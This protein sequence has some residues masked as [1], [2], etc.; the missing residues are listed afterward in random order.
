MFTTSANPDHN[1]RFAR[2]RLPC[3]AGYGGL[4]GIHTAMGFDLRHIPRI[5]SRIVRMEGHVY[6]LWSP[7]STQLPFL[8][9][10]PRPD[11][12]PGTPRLLSERRY[13]GHAGRHDCLHAPQ[14]YRSRA[15]HW[16]FMRRASMVLPGDY[17][18]LAYAPLTRFWQRDPANPF[19][20]AFD[21]PF[22]AGLSALRR[23]L[24]QQMET[25]RDLASYRSR[26]RPSNKPTDWE[27]R[28]AYATEDS[29]ARL[30]A[31]RT[32]DEAVD[33]G[34][35]VQ[36]GLREKEA[37]LHLFEARNQQ[38]RLPF[39]LLK[40]EDMPLAQERFIGV[41]INGADEELTLRYMRAGVPCFIAHEYTSSTLTRDQVSVVKVY[42]D[43]LEGTELPELL[44]D[45]NPYQR[46]ARNQGAL[47]NIVLG[48]DGRGL[49]LPALATDE[50]RSS[51]LFLEQLAPLETS[52]LPSRAPSP[53]R[54]DRQS[55]GAPSQAAP[56]KDWRP[57]PRPPSPREARS[58]IEKPWAQAGWSA[59]APS[60]PS[61]ADILPHA[62]EAP[63]SSR[64][65]RDKYQARPLEYQSV[66]PQRSSWIVPP[67]IQKAPDKGKWVKFELDEVHQLPAFV[68]RGA[69]AEVESSNL[70]YDRENKRRLYFGHFVPP[71]GVLDEDRFGAPVPRYPFFAEDGNR[72]APQPP[73]NWMYTTPDS[74]RYN[75]GKRA[76]A[77]AP[78]RLPLLTRDGNTAEQ[79][80]K[81]KGKVAEAGEEESEEEEHGMEVDVPNPSD[82][83]SSVV[84]L[85]G[86]DAQISAVEFARL[87][88][89]A[90]YA[91]RA[92]PLM[93]I[94]AQGRMWL[95]F[96][97]ITQGRGAFGAL[98]GVAR[99]IGVQFRPVAE[100]EE[101]VLY[102]TD[103]WYPE[104]DDE[105]P[106]QDVV[107]EM[108]SGIEEI[109]VSAGS[110]AVKAVSPSPPDSP[111][112]LMPT[113]PPVAPEP[114]SSR[115]NTR[116]GSKRSPESKAAQTPPTPTPVAPSSATAIPPSSTA[117][118]PLRTPAPSLRPSKPPPPPPSAPRAM[119]AATAPFNKP[120]LSDRLT[121]APVETTALPSGPTTPLIQR[122]EGGALPLARRLTDASQPL[123]QRLQPAPLLLR[124][125]H[126]SVSTAGDMAQ[127]EER[128]SASD[129]DA[130]PKAEGR[131]KGKRKV[132]RGTR[133]GKLAKEQARLKEERRAAREETSLL[134]SPVSTPA[135]S[136]SQ[137]SVVASSSAMTLDL[138][139]LP[140]NPANSTMSWDEYESGPFEAFVPPIQEQPLQPAPELG[141]PGATEPWQSS[142]Y[143]EEEVALRW[144]NEEDEEDRP[145]AGPF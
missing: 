26:S 4:P 18:E 57:Y 87:G 139:A 144:D 97:T 39:A 45:N 121:D 20:G 82:E 51:S 22:I 9:G 124:M 62:I 111:P 86:L 71:E 132:R 52:P 40:K 43:F 74:P 27:T 38:R 143:E 126:A 83:P 41:W 95:R 30:L 110:S 7:N 32:W 98:G 69:N 49:Q 99:D 119:R 73:S 66:D 90:F 141:P 8:A 17:A 70:W 44:G 79:A 10:V 21:P 2:T 34:V 53:S 3:L 13:D 85:D 120:P 37:W 16:P 48:D 56:S 128:D 47:D 94:R 54:E 63:S 129:P 108:E 68:R 133:A 137:P 115:P 65:S 107:M 106:G 11:W 77:P 122:L 58:A 84:V 140:S 92:T 6:E 35:A 64:A 50:M 112:S 131:G 142:M 138:V 78:A 101:R 88:R 75:V 102:T 31:V 104:T 89:D 93:I 42:A 123:A 15:K 125:S 114:T 130:A 134:P 76:V 12:M 136:S 103:V 14:Y 81:G 61:L 33:A 24:D 28:P 118:V 60:R 29:I 5:T 36:R 100:F 127:D 145:F 1:V 55:A 46:I 67:P 105:P 113:P 72:W 25:H 19:R 91:G 109:A 135:V 80:G 96:E 117:I 116:E 59:S 23:S